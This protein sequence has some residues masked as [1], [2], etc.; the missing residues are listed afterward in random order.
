MLETLKTMHGEKVYNIKLHLHIEQ[1][2]EG[3]VYAHLIGVTTSNAKGRVIPNSIDLSF[4]AGICQQLDFQLCHS[5]HSTTLASCQGRG[6]TGDQGTPTA[7]A[8]A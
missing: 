2:G 5:G 7:R 3:A 8:R 1:L 6:F 4:G